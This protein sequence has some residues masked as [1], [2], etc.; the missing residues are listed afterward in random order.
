MLLLCAL[1]FLALAAH[2]F[3]TYPASL[4][5]IRRMRKQ[6]SFARATPD[7]EPTFAILVPAYNEERIIRDKIENLLALQN[8]V[9]SCELLVYVD[10]ATDRTAELLQPYAERI[11]VVVGDIRRG[12]SHG[13]NVLVGRAT[14]DIL[15]F[16]DANVILDAQALHRL[17]THFSDPSVGCVSGHLKYGNGDESATAASGNMYWKL[18]ERIR[19]L[20]SDTVGI[21]GVDGSLFAT[22]RSLHVVVPADII[23][24]FYVSMKI[25][26]NGHRVVRAPDAFAFERTGSDAHEEFGRK[27]RIACQ[28][29]NVHRLLWSEIRKARAGIVYAYVSHRLLKWLIAYNLVLAGV[30]ALA[31][32]LI[33]MNPLYVAIIAASTA[34]GFA[35]GW[36]LNLRP[37]PQ[38]GSMLIAFAGVGWG[39]FRSLRGDRFQ[40]W[41]PMTTARA[42][43]D[44]R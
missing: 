11:T 40:T 17:G 10:A 9:R 36:L 26:L 23:D 34:G 41:A 28:A 14:A 15:V 30:L 29:F 25:L 8:S 35:A 7:R 39:V 21:V 19:Q 2:P 4:H 16:S 3:T 43:A 44:A 33:E 27:V 5:L 32:M 20:E 13:L 22:R 37:F 6:T 12:K 1:F 18:E 31:W 24:D 42:R 38:I